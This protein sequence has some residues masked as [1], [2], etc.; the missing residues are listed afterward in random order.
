MFFLTTANLNKQTEHTDEQRRHKVSAKLM[1]KR[2]GTGDVTSKRIIDRLIRQQNFL[3]SIGTI[4]RNAF[5]GS[6]VHMPTQRAVKRMIDHFEISR[7]YLWKYQGKARALEYL[8]GKVEGKN[9]NVSRGVLTNKLLPTWQ[10]VPIDVYRN[11]SG[12]AIKD[13]FI[14]F[15]FLPSEVNPD[16]VES[17]Q[18][19]TLVYLLAVIGL[20][21]YEY[22]LES[23][24]KAKML[25]A[26][27][28]SARIH[29][30]T[31]EFLMPTV[32]TEKLRG[33]K[34]TAAKRD[35]LANKFKV[36]P[37]ALIITLRR[38]GIISKKVYESLKPPKFVPKKRT[39]NDDRRSPKMSTSVKKFCGE[40]SYNAI[41]TGI[42]NGSLT[43]I[44]AQYL[45]Y[46]AVYKAGYRKYRN[47]LGI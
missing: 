43:S 1:T 31:T 5:C 21:K 19:Y 14:P 27:G 37:S 40:M 36:S 30:I 10:V 4:P 23:D 45:I 46:G 13:D 41:N 29:A 39:G 22:Y 18:I 6:L 33:K 38:R 42:R 15:V 17:R 24:F 3:T 2:R 9:I 28:L 11:T 16:E 26:T 34:I 12:F 7:E 20:G 47:E 44:Q 35:E 25:N 32:E 8:V